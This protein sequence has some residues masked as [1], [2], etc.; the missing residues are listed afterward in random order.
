MRPPFLLGAGVALALAS[1]HPARAF[2]ADRVMA[3]CLAGFQA[4]MTAASRTPPAG[5]A[6]FTCRCFLD[7]VRAGSP[8]EKATA[9]C[10]DRAAARFPLGQ[11]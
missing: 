9:L 11:P 3:F 6:D 4:A 1:P 8:I 2:D 7:R 10:R 5:M